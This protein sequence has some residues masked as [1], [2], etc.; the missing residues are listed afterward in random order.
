MCVCAR[1]RACAGPAFP[2]TKGYHGTVAVGSSIYIA[3]G[4]SH[5]GWHK[6]TWSLD[7][8]TGV[9]TQ[10]RGW[11]GAHTNLRFHIHLFAFACVSHAP[12][13]RR[14]YVMHASCIKHAAQPLSWI[15]LRVRT[16]MA[17]LLW[18]A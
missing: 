9:W 5:E 1:A 15:R 13:M 17:G 11:E 8:R 10:V 14:A 16:G 7:V 4:G 12:R 2:L 18:I 3:G 6:D